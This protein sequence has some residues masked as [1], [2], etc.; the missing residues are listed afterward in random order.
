MQGSLYLSGTAATAAALRIIGAVNFSDVAIRIFDYIMALDNVSALQPN[1]PSR[2]QPEK[3]SGRK[4]V[5]AK[6]RFK[7]ASIFE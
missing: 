2:G 4:P 7:T 5:S 6:A 1:F 3:F